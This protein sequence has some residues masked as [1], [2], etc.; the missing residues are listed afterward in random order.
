MVVVAKHECQGALLVQGVGGGLERQLLFQVGQRDCNVS[1]LDWDEKR[2]R[3]SELCCVYFALVIGCIAQLANTAV[4][5]LLLLA[6][7]RGSQTLIITHAVKCQLPHSYRFF[8]PS[9]KDLCAVSVIGS[10]QLSSLLGVG[11]KDS[12]IGVSL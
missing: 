11:K 1:L 7:Q 12:H 9:N 8:E 3:G 2:R 6:D 5:S 4:L 10:Q